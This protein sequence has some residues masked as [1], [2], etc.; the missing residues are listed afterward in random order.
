M[1]KNIT[2]L[3]YYHESDRLACNKSAKVSLRERHLGF[4][5]PINVCGPGLSIAHYGSIIISSKAKIGRN[6]RIHSCVNIGAS[7]G[8]NGAPII[9]NNVYIGPGAIL[10]GDITIADNVSI[11]ANATVN[12]S[13][14]ESNVVIAGTPAEIVKRNVP[15][16]NEV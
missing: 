6:C 10:F 8:K 15:A 9:G 13:F 2:D 14:T 11:G 12:R 3:R 1:I 7:R 4:S 5:I 16:W